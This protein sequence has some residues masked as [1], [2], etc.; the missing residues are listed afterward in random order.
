[1][2]GPLIRRDTRRPEGGYCVDTKW[3]APSEAK[4]G[5]GCRG[6]PPSAG[7]WG[8]RIVPGCGCQ[9][10][11]EVGARRVPPPPGRSVPAL[12][13]LEPL[14]RGLGVGASYLPFPIPSG[15]PPPGGH[16]GADGPS[17]PR[18]ASLPTE[19]QAEMSPRSAQHCWAPNLDE[20]V[21]RPTRWVRPGPRPSPAAR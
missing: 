21:G 15:T 3:S 12:P 7:P 1:M 20:R 2:W 17:P 11:E 10:Q 5:H 13:Q 4:T 14:T 9:T 19:G 16:E 18:S 8:L 6:R